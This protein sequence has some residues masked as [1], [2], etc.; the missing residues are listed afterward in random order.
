MIIDKVGYILLEPKAANLFPQLASSRHERAALIVTSNKPFSPLGRSFRRRR[1]RRDDRP[2]SPP[3]RVIALKRLIP[4]ERPRP[5]TRP[6]HSQRPGL[7]MTT[8]RRAI[9]HPSIRGSL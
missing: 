4:A 9:R 3:G 6:H 5:R 2:I 1:G 8:P 7:T